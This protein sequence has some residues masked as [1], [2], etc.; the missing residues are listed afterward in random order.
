MPKLTK[1]ETSLIDVKNKFATIDNT[2]KYGSESIEKM[3]GVINSLNK[4][5]PLIEKT[6]T[7]ASDLSSDASS[8]LQNTQNNL[9]DLGP[10]IKRD[11]QILNSV[12]A[13]AATSA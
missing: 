10:I 5:M 1:I 8:F 9:S 4:N 6:I 3:N 11:L 7:T 2:V 12:S 13:S